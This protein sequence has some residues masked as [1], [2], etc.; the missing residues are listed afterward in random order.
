LSS[1]LSARAWFKQAFW[2]TLRDSLSLFNDGPL[3][4]VPSFFNDLCGLSFGEVA[5]S[6]FD[7]SGLLQNGRHLLLLLSNN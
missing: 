5:F 4:T 7:L 2:S 6:K 3:L 1:L